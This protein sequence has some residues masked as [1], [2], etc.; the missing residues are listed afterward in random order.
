M[1]PRRDEGMTLL[2]V[3]F[4]IS[5]LLIGI[6]FVVKSDS[7]MYHYRSQAEIRQR[8][9]L[10]A[11]GQLERILENQSIVQ[12]SES[13]NPEYSCFHVEFSASDYSGL[14]LAPIQG[15]MKVITVTV[16]VT[17][18]TVNSPDPVTM[19]TCRVDQS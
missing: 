3:V 18:Q 2:E 10:Y 17:P 4:A 11:A 14:D 7:A 16:S 19:S 13:G 1:R 15:Q 8:M 9:L 5:I 6:T 12:G